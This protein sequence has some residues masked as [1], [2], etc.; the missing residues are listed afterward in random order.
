MTATA[1]ALAPN[2]PGINQTAGTEAALDH[3]QRSTATA[4][5]EI[6]ADRF[7]DDIDLP[8]HAVAEVMIEV[9]E[10]LISAFEAD[11]QS[12]P[13]YQFL[14]TVCAQAAEV[15]AG[16]L[17]L[18]NFPTGTEDP[19][20]LSGPVMLAYTGALCAAGRHDQAIA[21]LTRLVEKAP[22]RASLILAMSFAE[23]HRA[24]LAAA[25]AVH[26][27]AA[28]FKGFVI[29]LDRLPGKYDG[30]LSR[31]AASNVIFERL[32]ASDGAQMSED[33]V[34]THKLVARGSQFTRG[35]VGC[36]ASHMRI[37][38]AVAQQSEPALVFE[39][40]ATVRFD[41]N[42]RLAELLPRLGNWDYVT[43]GYN[44]DAVLD[45][46]FAPGLRATTAFQPQQL[47]DEA[48][49]VFQAST[50]PV[51]GF[52][53]HTCFGTPGYVVSP[54]GARKLLQLCFPMRNRSH[55]VALLGRDLT[56]AGIDRMMNCIFQDIEAYACFAPLVIPRNDTR[57]STTMQAS[58]MRAW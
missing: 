11:R 17:E 10:A 2:H 47:N 9:A 1:T 30:F 56:V 54:A 43:L 45:I 37:W 51:N 48:D 49:A 50:T 58:D 4:A 42:E 46:E 7:R 18:A 25:P 39:D 12:Q 22:G 41:I 5:L 53:L 19:T 27:A 24:G 15:V 6:F 52:R 16:L 8:D 14:Q 29:N 35:A 23:R 36:A 13:A 44:I 34:I 31:N 3:L 26:A 38:N 40:D 28:R 57:T 33:E 20:T 55:Y 32:P 21:V